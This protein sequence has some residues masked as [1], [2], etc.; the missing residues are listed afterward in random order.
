MLQAGSGAILRHRNIGFY[1]LR[2]NVSYPVL[3]LIKV[4]H[5][6]NIRVHINAV[7]LL[8]IITMLD[9]CSF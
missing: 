8:T 9:L 5:S 3:Q 1:E 6:L 4:K 7:T 2:Y